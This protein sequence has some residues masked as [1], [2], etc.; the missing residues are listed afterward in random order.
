MLSTLSTCL[1][2]MLALAVVLFR[3]SREI[4]QKRLEKRAKEAYESIYKPADAAYRSSLIWFVNNK[5]RR[6]SMALLQFHQQKSKVTS[7]VEVAKLRE[8]YNA[9]VRRETELFEIA[10]RKLSDDLDN[11]RQRAEAAKQAI[12]DAAKTKW[13]QRGRQ[14]ISDYFS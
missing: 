14:R 7:A 6:I 12:F 13:W 5:R 10:A 9:T 4:R 2:L 3:P 11:S 8:A 1:F